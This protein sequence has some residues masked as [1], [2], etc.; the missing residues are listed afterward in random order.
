L[1]E[2]AHQ[3]T[4]DLFTY[5]IV[6]VDNDFRQ[7][8]RDTT[9]GLK[10]QSRLEIEYSSE[11]RQNI[12]LA[13]NKAIESAPGNLIAFIDDDEIPEPTWLLNLYQAYMNFH[14]DGVL[15]PV[16][17]HFEVEPPAWIIKGKLLERES[18]ATGTILRNIRHMRTGNVLFSRDILNEGE[19]PFDPRFGR[20]GGEDTD[21][22]KRMIKKGAL[23]IW[24]NE[25]CVYE[26]IPPQRLKRAYLLKRGFLR[27]VANSRRESLSMK[28]AFKSFMAFSIYTMSLPFL[29]LIGHHL[30]M[31]CLIKDCDHM[32]KLLASCGLEVVKERTF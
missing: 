7:S 26:R 25:A 31:K 9:E 19:N 32:G 23:F 14:A 24:C 12:A 11:P 28:G 13:R 18:F 20:T 10:R 16:N 2:L 29:F 5:S 22:F 17:P 6:V 1:T 3:A 21:F 15:G 30:F 27:G 4:D 8:A